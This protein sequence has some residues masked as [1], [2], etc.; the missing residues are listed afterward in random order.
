MLVTGAGAMPSV[1]SSDELS[2]P[3]VWASVIAMA[4]ILLA[5]VPLKA[6]HPP[7]AATALLIALG[8]FSLNA[9]TMAILAAGILLTTALGEMLRRL[10]HD[11][12]ADRG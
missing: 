10:R 5:Q 3:R 6:S 8:G 12:Q 11:D 7:A 9:R 4:L 2:W 1:L